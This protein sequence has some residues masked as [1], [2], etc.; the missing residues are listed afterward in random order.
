MNG[1]PRGVDVQ[2]IAQ[3]M[4]NGQ[5][6]WWTVGDDGTRSLPAHTDCIHRR[7]RLTCTQYEALVWR[8][9]GACEVCKR[10][11][12]EEDNGWRQVSGRLQIDHDHQ[13]GLWAVRGLLCRRCNNTI[14]RPFMHPAY[15]TY[16]ANAYYRGLLAE[17]GVT[18]ET[19]TEPPMDSV[20]LDYV[21]REWRRT[22]D[23]WVALHNHDR[24]FAYPPSWAEL[25]YHSGPH[26]LRIASR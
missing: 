14:D 21:L 5:Y 17:A 2:L 7:Y 9:A 26:N 4:N 12:S 18:A 16:S 11:A 23:G 13:L 6:A 22:S 1:Q 24:M 19:P 8:S 3:R 15:E 20:V 10:P 25:I